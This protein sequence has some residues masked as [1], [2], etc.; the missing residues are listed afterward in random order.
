MTHKVYAIHFQFIN[1]ERDIC[2]LVKGDIIRSL[3]GRLYK[4]INPKDSENHYKICVVNDEGK[5]MNLNSIPLF[6][7]KQGSL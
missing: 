3:S 7:Y 4:I 2:N 5:D 1:L 6:I